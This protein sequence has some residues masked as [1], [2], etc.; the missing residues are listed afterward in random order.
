MKNRGCEWNAYLCLNTHSAGTA[1]RTVY[2]CSAHVRRDITFLRELR[3]SINLSISSINVK[4]KRTEYTRQDGECECTK[5]HEKKQR[6]DFARVISLQKKIPIKRIRK[7]NECHGGW[8]LHEPKR[9]HNLAAAA[10]AILMLLQLL[11]LLQSQL[12][13]LVQGV[14]ELVR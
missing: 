1:D 2:L 14:E 13:R 9:S 7:G 4:R 3:S 5:I 11:L 10:A 12:L 6:A 8:R